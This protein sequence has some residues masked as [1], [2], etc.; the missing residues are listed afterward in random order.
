MCKRGADD[1]DGNYCC[2]R[3]NGL[4]GS[5]ENVPYFCDKYKGT[6]SK[7]KNPCFPS[8]AKV[9]LSD[10]TSIRI[11]KLKER[12]SIMAATANGMMTI[13]DVSVLSIADA[14]HNDI[15]FLKFTTATGVNVTV[16]AEHHLSIGKSCCSTLR[17]AK[18]VR[19]GDTLYAAK[20]G[21]VVAER[22]VMINKVLKQGL[23]S[24]VLV[25]GNFPIVDGI[26]TS[27]D[28]SMVVRIMGTLSPYG[29]SLLD[30]TGTAAIFRRTFLEHDRK[31][32]DGFH[33]V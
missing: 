27:F 32:I 23:Y 17:Q 4:A 31:Y 24:P 7:S 14:R 26:V 29:L 10:G 20:E 18:N 25:N 11:D 13:D 5:A 1:P 22:V 2:C 15:L 33:A 16:T 3:S 19:I 12:D 9:T 30:V 28:S 8:D 6:G 21:A